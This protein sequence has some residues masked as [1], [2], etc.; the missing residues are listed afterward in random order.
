[1]TI[2][3]DGELV[4]VTG[5]FVD[6]P[7]ILIGTRLLRRRILTVDFVAGTVQIASVADRSLLPSPSRQ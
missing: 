2:P 3:F 5:T 4:A 7:E 6:A 1:M